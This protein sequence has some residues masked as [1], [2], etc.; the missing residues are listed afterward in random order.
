AT[1]YTAFL[2]QC[3]EALNAGLS[4]KNHQYVASLTG[5]AYN[6]RAEKRLELVQRLQQ[7]GNSRFKEVFGEAMADFGNA[8]INGP[9]RYR[10]WMARGVAHVNNGNY[11]LGIKDFTQVIKLKP[12]EA[13]AWFNRAEALYQRS[14]LGCGAQPIIVLSND[15]NQ[16][17]Q[18]NQKDKNQTLSDEV[19]AIGFKQAIR[20]YDTVLRFDSADKEALTGRGHTNYA[21]GNVE[22]ALADYEKVVEMTSK[23]PASSVM[24]LIN[25]GDALQRLGRWE[26]AESDYQAAIEKSTSPIAMQRMAWFQSTCPVKK[27]RNPQSAKQLIANAIAAAGETAKNL[28]TQ[29]AVE[30]A[31]GNFEVAKTTQAKVIGLASAELTVDPEEAEARLAM[32]EEGKPFEQTGK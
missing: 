7:I 21:L 16:A 19:R 14:R 27:H 31:L 17:N 2:K 3:D 4:K 26:A 30:A 11:D 10:S 18:A 32:Y 13:N 15:T 29:A 12:D 28:D 25:R 24:A 23:N 20:D 6:R 8:V 22:L 1:D 5:W 9:E